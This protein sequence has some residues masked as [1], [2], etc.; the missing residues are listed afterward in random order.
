MADA[1]IFGGDWCQTVSANNAAG[2]PTTITLAGAS[3]RAATHGVRVWDTRDFRAAY[4]GVDYSAPKYFKLLDAA[5]GSAMY[6]AGWV[7][8]QPCIYEV[9]AAAYRIACRAGSAPAGFAGGLGVALYSGA[10][11]ACPTAAPV[12][13][14]LGVVGGPRTAAGGWALHFCL[15]L[16]GPVNRGKLMYIPYAC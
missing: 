13:P 3:H 15:R 1:D 12:L 9:G 7:P 6:H 10:A 8:Q 14:P 4:V 2:V 5:A 11:G 16:A